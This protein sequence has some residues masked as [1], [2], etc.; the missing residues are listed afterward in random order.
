VNS[1]IEFSISKKFVA[2]FLTCSAV[3]SLQQDY[4]GRDET[5][6]HVVNDWVTA[7]WTVP[8]ALVCLGLAVWLCHEPSMDPQVEV[9]PAE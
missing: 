3:R 1:N 4:W 8:A 6:R 2:G 9:P 5:I 7:W